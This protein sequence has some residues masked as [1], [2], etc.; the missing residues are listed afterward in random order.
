MNNLFATDYETPDGVG[1][2]FAIG[3]RIYRVELPAAKR[4]E[5]GLRSSELT[6]NTAVLL[7]RYFSG[8]QVSFD[9]IPVSFEDVSPFYMKVQLE[10]RR[11]PFGAVRSYGEVAA[12]CGSP[13]SSRAVGGAMAHNRLPIIVPCH[14]VVAGNGA[15][16]GF[17]GAG[18]I[19][20]KFRLL[21]MEGIEFNGLKV[22]VCGGL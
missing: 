15:L 22:V 16:T 20:A 7:Q 11:I 14:R 13:R 21:Q 3:D 17:S 6:R 4:E 9:A 5:E 19:Q 2:V 8:E 1:R 18:G 10:V 12:L